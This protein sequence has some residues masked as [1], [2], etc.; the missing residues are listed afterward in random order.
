MSNAIATLPVQN[1]SDVKTMQLTHKHKWHQQASSAV[2]EAGL[3]DAPGANMYYKL[4]E[5]ENAVQAAECVRDIFFYLLTIPAGTP[6]PKDGLND[7]AVVKEWHR[8]YST[9]PKALLPNI[10]ALGADCKLMQFVFNGTDVGYSK[11]FVAESLGHKTDSAQAFLERWWD[12]LRMISRT[13]YESETDVIVHSDEENHYQL[14]LPRLVDILALH[15]EIVDLGYWNPEADMLTN[16]ISCNL[17]VHRVIEYIRTELN[18]SRQDIRGRLSTDFYTSSKTLIE[19]YGLQSVTRADVGDTKDSSTRVGRAGYGSDFDDRNQGVKNNFGA[20]LPGVYNTF[21]R[22]MFTSFSSDNVESKTLQQRTAMMSH[23]FNNYRERTTPTVMTLEHWNYI[24]RHAGWFNTNHKYVRDGITTQHHGHDFLNEIINTDIALLNT[25]TPAEHTE[26]KIDALHLKTVDNLKRF[27][28]PQLPDDLRAQLPAG[29]EHI[30]TPP[31]L[32]TEG[33]VMHHCCGGDRYMRDVSQGESWFFHVMGQD[34]NM[35][36]TCEL[37]WGRHGDNDFTESQSRGLQNCDPMESETAL[38]KQLMT[39][40]N[41]YSA[42][43]EN[44]DWVSNSIKA[45]SK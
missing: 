5:T 17:S 21:C 35:G 29:I 25:R 6:Y 39:L 2:F 28:F 12:Q 27:S 8:I 18:L 43:P 32:Y 36:T 9:T 44:K 11:E 15:H 4:P 30:S 23:I 14:T 13:A 3:R 45:V 33:T 42:L 34:S 26:S 22:Y 20:P 38:I 1:T 37:E 24:L 41:Q 16:L 19:L 31:Q 7:P 10:N 40:I